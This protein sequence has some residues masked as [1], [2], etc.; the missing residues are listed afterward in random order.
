[1]SIDKELDSEIFIK[2]FMNSSLAKKLDLKYNH[3]QW[4][5]NEYIMECILDE[6]KDE[7][8]VGKTY[9][10][11]MMYWTGYLT[12]NSIIILEKQ[13]KR[14]INKQMHI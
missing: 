11:E 6:M 13:V 2:A 12:V 10:K 5:D 4:A 3:L 1:M 7:L 8:K 9:D 14:Y